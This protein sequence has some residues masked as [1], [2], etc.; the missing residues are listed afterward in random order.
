V[1]LIR[2]KMSPL[3][4]GRAGGRRFFTETSYFAAM[5]M[6]KGTIFAGF[7]PAGPKT[8]F[9]CRKIC[10]LPFL[11]VVVFLVI[12]DCSANIISSLYVISTLHF[13]CGFCYN[14]SLMFISPDNK[15]ASDSIG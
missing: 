5:T 1:T 15:I 6:Q 14:I 4:R 10:H 12:L 3:I 8:G 2:V 13:C 11:K 9:L 7:S